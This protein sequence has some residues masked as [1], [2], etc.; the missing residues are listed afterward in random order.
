MVF[1]K[2]S[3]EFL[4][5][6]SPATYLTLENFSKK[7]RGGETVEE[8]EAYTEEEEEED[9]LSATCYNKRL[10]FKRCD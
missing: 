4:H 9:E 7:M 10:T 3:S 1:C 6:P 2:K 5:V 8:E